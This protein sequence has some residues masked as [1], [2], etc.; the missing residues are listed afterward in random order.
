MRC[1]LFDSPFFFF[2]CIHLGMIVNTVDS[3]SG[4][5]CLPLR[6]NFLDVCCRVQRST[7][8][9]QGSRYYGVYCGSMSLGYSP[10][11]INIVNEAASIM[12]P[13]KLTSFLWQRS[14]PG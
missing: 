12:F 9:G 14:F 6:M 2:Y 3:I 11:N 8:G 5:T 13:S 4:E 10:I 1:F 7:R